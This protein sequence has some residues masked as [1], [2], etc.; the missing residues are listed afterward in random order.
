MDD[1]TEKTTQ[2]LMA[3]LEALRARVASQEALAQRGGL[4]GDPSEE[5]QNLADNLAHFVLYQA[6]ATPEGGR[7]IL[8]VSRALE[9][10]NELTPEAL[11]ADANLIYDQMLPEYRAMVQEREQEALRTRS[12]FRAEVQSRLPSGRIRWF[13]FTSA[14]RYLPD[15]TLV[16]DGIEVDITERKEAEAALREVSQFNREII[17]S[18]EQG[19]VV[20]GLDLTY[21]LWNPYMEQITG[22]PARDVLGRTPDQFPFLREAGL[23]EA[24]EKTMAGVYCPPL[25]FFYDLP[26]TG[27]SGWASEAFSPQRNAQGEIVGVICIVEDITHRRET[28]VALREANQFSKAVID[29]AE[30]GICVCD[31]DL[32][33]LVWNACMEQLTGIPA[34]EALGQNVLECFP[35]LHEAGVAES[36]EKTLEGIYVPP[37]EYQFNIPETGRSA[38]VSDSRNALRNAQG[39]I[40]GIIASILDITERK[41]IENELRDKNDAL[42]RC[43]QTVSQGLQASR[44]TIAALLNLA[45]NDP[46]S[47][48]N[49]MQSLRKAVGLMDGVLH[50]L[51]HYSQEGQE[52][53]H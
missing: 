32:H 37:V 49:C 23:P 14:P 51:E 6:T 46:E 40:V 19:I 38:W 9:R 44:E 24:L 33:C 2:A 27:R 7:Q 16:W 31:R 18:V 10:L 17:D 12:V 47:K 26:A 3:E 8:Y 52:S 43:V 35:F 41:R 13:E 42:E 22:M 48:P 20:H 50:D 29:S 15:G 4:P 5:F 34:E 53:Q 1:N 25:E 11:R 28:E 45:E 36:V 30:E 39:E 21:R